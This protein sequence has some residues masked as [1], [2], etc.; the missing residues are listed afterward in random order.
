MSACYI[1]TMPP[2]TTKTPLYTLCRG[3]FAVKFVHHVEGSLWLICINV[4][5][6]KAH[7]P[8]YQSGLIFI[9]TKHG[10]SRRLWFSS[11][12]VTHS[13]QPETSCAGTPRPTDCD[14]R[15]DWIWK[16][17]SGQ[18]PP[19]MWPSLSWLPLRG[20]FSLDLV[21]FSLLTWLP[22][23]GLLGFSLMISF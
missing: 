23:Q 13:S 22:L 21:C 6:L 2:L 14:R 20:L 7:L 18:C 9:K 5:R 10:F 12:L 4:F 11:G 16:I 8:R 19:R 15:G 17:F 1:V 3:V